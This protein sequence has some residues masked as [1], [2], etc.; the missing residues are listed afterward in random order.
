MLLKTTIFILGPFNT[1]LYYL[2][3]VLGS[4]LFVLEIT[5]MNS[6]APWKII[7]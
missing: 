1:K 2:G 5:L 4:L 7:L 3:I 6:Q